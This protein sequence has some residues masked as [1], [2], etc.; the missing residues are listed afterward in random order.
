[1]GARGKTP[2]QKVEIATRQAE[3]VRLAAQGLTYAQIATRLGYADPSGAYVAVQAVLSRVEHSNADGLRA[4]QGA[5]LA[6]L[7]AAWLPY[8]TYSEKAAELV[9]KIHA[10]QARLFGLDAPVKVDATI[11]D[12]TDRA[13]A[14]LAEQLGVLA[15]GAKPPEVAET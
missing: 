14:E 5:R 11:A 4:V 7:E 12:A 15:D 1:M 3:A 2:E 9:L 8:A 13:I 10:R 6:A